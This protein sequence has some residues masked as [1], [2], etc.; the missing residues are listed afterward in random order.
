[1]EGPNARS[2]RVRP[3]YPAHRLI[4]RTPGRARSIRLLVPREELPDL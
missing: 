4:Q 2:R 1:M 3:K